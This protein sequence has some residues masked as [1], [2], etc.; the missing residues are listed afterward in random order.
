MSS[1]KG[2]TSLPFCEVVTK[3]IL[4]QSCTNRDDYF[5]W[6]LLL[7]SV[8]FCKCE[9]STKKLKHTAFDGMQVRNFPS[10]LSTILD[11]N[12]PPDL[13]KLDSTSSGTRATL[14]NQ[15][16]CQ[17]GLVDIVIHS[18][19]MNNSFNRKLNKRQKLK[20]G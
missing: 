5:S 9:T 1:I 16:G 17:Y 6:K 2:Q 14:F 10:A 18:R 7:S 13:Q 15:M 20:I 12:F 8:R 19:W 4:H 3:N 11:F